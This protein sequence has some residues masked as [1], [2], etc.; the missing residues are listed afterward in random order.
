MPVNWIDVTSLSFNT[1]LLLERVQ[2]SWFPGWLP[3]APLAIALRANPSVEWYLRHKCPQ[4]TLWLDRVLAKNPPAAVSPEEVRTA[5]VTILNSLNDLITYAVD[6]SIYDRLAFTAWDDR[7]LLDL[8]DFRGKIVLDIGA[9]PGRLALVAAKAGATAVYAVE[10]VENLRRYLLEKARAR[11]LNNLYA[12]D[13]LLT[14][15]PF[16]DGFASVV[17]GGHVFGD[18]P[19]A[20]LAEMERVTRPGGKIILMPGNNDVDNDRHAFLLAHGFQWACFP[21]QPDMVRKY[22]KTL[23]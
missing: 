4:I 18:D 19:A 16:A 12:V 13:G 11:G 23:A 10:P 14:T 3:E 2:L 22:W 7:E 15:I 1:L 6:P 21:E 17:M 8:V 20:E 9:G 5:E